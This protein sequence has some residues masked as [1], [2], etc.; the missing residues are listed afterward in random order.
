M[1]RVVVDESG[2]A[3]GFTDIVSI[4]AGYADSFALGHDGRVLSWGS[5]FHGA[6]GRTTTASTDNTPGL[7]VT[8][9]G[10]LSLTPVAYPNLLRRL[11]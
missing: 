2:S 8:A 11:H 9:G 10:V 4:A 1:P 6:L 5:N 3:S 7:V